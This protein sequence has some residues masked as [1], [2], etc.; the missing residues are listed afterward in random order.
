MVSATDK[1]SISYTEEIT[2]IVKV[3]VYKTGIL[4]VQWYDGLDEIDL[5]SMQQLMECVRK[6]GKGEKVCLYMSVNEFV[7][8]T[9]DALSYAASK[10]CEDL[11]L[12]NA[13]L[14][15]NLAKKLVF[16]F[17]LRVNKP[18]TPTKTFGTKEEAFD[19]LIS[20]MN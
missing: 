12:A 7:T 9:M 14:V 18:G 17:Y 11:T 16:N 6:V 3:H 20:F 13:V 5:K 1:Y 10:E 15:D 8:I 4:E 19:W 2:G